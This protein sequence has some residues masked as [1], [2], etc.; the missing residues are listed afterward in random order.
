M[1]P[2]AND[3]GILIIRLTL[4]AAL[5][6]HGLLKYFVFTLAGTVGFFESLG[7]PWFTAYLVFLGEVGG[8]LLLIAGYQ[9]RLIAALMTPIL[10]G[11]SVVHIPNGWVFSA[12]GGG[13]EYPIFMTATSIALVFMG[14]G[15]ISVKRLLASK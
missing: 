3:Y 2:T 10:I 4:G 6:A 1:K 13:W 7:L 5:L 8:G 15:A 9:T 11:A 14:D 12:Q